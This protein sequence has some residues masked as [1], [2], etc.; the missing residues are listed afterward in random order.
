MC[1]VSLRPSGLHE[2]QAVTCHQI[3]HLTA[4]ALQP[5]LSWRHDHAVARQSQTADAQHGSMHLC[6]FE[7]HCSDAR[8]LLH[9]Q[10]TLSSKWTMMV[11]L[12]ALRVRYDRG[13]THSSSHSM[14]WEDIAHRSAVYQD[15]LVA[16]LL[17][18]VFARYS[19]KALCNFTYLSRCNK[20]S[21]V[22]F[23]FW[24][25]VSL[26]RQSIRHATY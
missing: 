22:L 21:S 4:V 24:V 19:T 7:V 23:F 2:R 20:Y 5:S 13:W 25:F 12:A 6:H 10:H 8:E 18:G 15:Q 11:P 17:R 3:R 26:T 14:L 9:L 16:P 1:C